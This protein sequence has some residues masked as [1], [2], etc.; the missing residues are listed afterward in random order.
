MHTFHS[1]RGGPSGA[2][3]NP[4]AVAAWCGP[5]GGRRGIASVLAMMY[6][7]IFAVLALGFYATVAIAA[8]L[9]G[10]EQRGA[11]AQ[12]AAESGLQFLRYQMSR[13]DVPQNL[14]PDDQFKQVCTQLAANLS[15]TGNVGAAGVAYD[16]NSLTFPAAGVVRL[17]RSGMRGFRVTLT[18]NGAELVS[19]VVGC[20]E[21]AHYFR[22]IEVTF[23]KLPR[24]TTIF[25]YGVASR[26][27]I[28]T[29]G[30]STIKGQTDPAR[31]SII[32]TTISSPAVSIN[33][34]AVSGD[35]CMT[36]KSSAVYLG[37]GVSVGGTTNTALIYKEH[38]HTDLPDPRFPDVDTSVYA[39]YATNTYVSGM[40]ALDNC[41]IPAGVSCSLSGGAVIR[42]VLYLEKGA[43]LHC[44]G[45]VT[46]QGV[47]VASNDATVDL[48]NNVIE[49]G[50]Q[51]TSLSIKDLPESFGEVRNL[52]GAFIIAPTYR[53]RFWGNVGNITG[54][55]ICGQFQMGGSAEGTIVG[56]II[57]MLDVPTTISG[58]ADVFIAG[59]AD[60]Q[61]P[62]G[63]TFGTYY[64]A[65]QSTYL[66]VRP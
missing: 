21:T 14:S 59:T 35:I 50:G 6:L 52:T 26:G 57:Q 62:V 58:S 66:E 30:S 43:S 2:A 25:N 29:S 61:I 46:V 40:S 56:T 10:N 36:G 37:S 13:L 18:R 53:V 60:I 38:V 41:R 54:T 16:G 3:A 11:S 7:V 65:R 51:V 32:T 27:P 19:R 20:D 45:G 1:R 63:V 4:G 39:K 34:K 17:D 49:F 12:V 28:L 47:I 24:T 44:S 15:G 31:G 8:Q 9:A 33:G 48:A 55:I 5:R 42:G 23:A 64:G 22:G